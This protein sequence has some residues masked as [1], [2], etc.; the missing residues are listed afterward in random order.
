MGG[1]DNFEQ[2]VRTDFKKKV[3]VEQMLAGGA[4]LTSGGGVF[5]QRE[6]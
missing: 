5:M 2:S 3:M 4:M 1:D 6:E